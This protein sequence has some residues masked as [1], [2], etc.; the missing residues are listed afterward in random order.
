MAPYNGS[1]P[2]M[3]ALDRYLLDHGVYT[4][5]RWWTVMTNPPLCI[6]EDQLA[7]GFEV[8]DH[9]LAETDEAVAAE[10]ATREGREP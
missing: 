1:S 7:E 10:R 6:T 5:V 4:M 3:K 8:I 2:E 9:A